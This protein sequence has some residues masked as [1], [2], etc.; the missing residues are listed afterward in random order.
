MEQYQI[1]RLLLE[2][3][4]GERLIKPLEPDFA[5]EEL[6]SHTFRALGD[7]GKNVGFSANVQLTAYDKNQILSNIEKS[8]RIIQE[9]Q[10]AFDAYFGVCKLANRELK[11][12]SGDLEDYKLFEKSIK[13]LQLYYGK[14]M[15]WKTEVDAGKVYSR[16]KDMRSAAEYHLRNGTA[17]EKAAAKTSLTFFDNVIE[18]NKYIDALQNKTYIG[19]I[20]IE[21]IARDSFLGE[22]PVKTVVFAARKA[23]AAEPA[24]EK[25]KQ[26]APERDPYEEVHRILRDPHY[27][28]RLEETRFKIKPSRN[29]KERDPYEEVHR[30]LRDPY[31]VPQLEEPFFRPALRFFKDAI[32]CFT[33]LF[34]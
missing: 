22:T 15:T 27:V 32:R 1:E 26:P 31:Y 14:I 9:F 25:E 17:Q 30:I 21:T 12:G 23:P 33:E 20:G 7:A 24:P 8:E 19:Q 13:D 28:P 34:N 2:A 16:I 5:L 6:V 4:E 29:Q 18:E 3:K 11:T 10:N